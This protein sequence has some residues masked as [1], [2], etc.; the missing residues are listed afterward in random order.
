MVI[1]DAHIRTDV[2]RRN[3]HDRAPRQGREGTAAHRVRALHILLIPCNRR[4]LGLRVPPAA[5]PPRGEHPHTR[6]SPHLTCRWSFREHGS[7]PHDMIQRSNKSALTNCA[8]SQQLRM[9][10]KPGIQMYAWNNE[11]IHPG[12]M[13]CM[14]GYAWQKTRVCAAVHAR[15]RM[16]ENS[17][18]NC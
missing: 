16:A 5:L 8:L 1:A 7:L 9:I 18:M 4:Q 17:R 14:H 13:P 10:E 2:V 11:C 6:W 15:L 12:C 3:V